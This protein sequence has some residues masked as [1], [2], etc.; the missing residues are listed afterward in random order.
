MKISGFN[1][2]GFL[3]TGASVYR[4][5]IEPTALHVFVAIICLMLDMRIMGRD[6]G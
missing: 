2:L 3:L 5:V 6:D 1:Y 4:A